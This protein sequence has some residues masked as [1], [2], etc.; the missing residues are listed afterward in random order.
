MA[1]EHELIQK[2]TEIAHG[3]IVESLPYSDIVR[4]SKRQRVPVEMPTAKVAKLQHKIVAA[5]RTAYSAG[6]DAG[7][8]TGVR[9]GMTGTVDGGS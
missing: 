8:S 3:L 6:F 1:S 9:V 5:L 2:F 7:V 4:I